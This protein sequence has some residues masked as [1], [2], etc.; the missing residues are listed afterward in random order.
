MSEKN[1][2]KIDVQAVE[3]LFY[4]KLKTVPEI[5][6]ETGF[7]LGKVHR[8]ITEIIAKRVENKPTNTPPIKEISEFEQV[9]LNAQNNSDFVLITNNESLKDFRK[10]L[11]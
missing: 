3:L 8:C 2:S 6:K 10:F 5:A 9:F 1:F 7:R 11:T 4:Y